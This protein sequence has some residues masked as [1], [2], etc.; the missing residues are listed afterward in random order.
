MD[1][2]VEEEVEETIIETTTVPAVPIQEPVAAPVVPIQEPIS[3]PSSPKPVPAPI[4]EPIPVPVNDE[5]D[6]SVLDDSSK[7][8]RFN[9]TDAVLTSTNQNQEI[10]VPKDIHSIEEATN[11]R[12]ARQRLEEE[13][14]SIGGEVDTDKFTIL[15][16]DVDPSAF[17]I[18]PIGQTDDLDLDI[19]ILQ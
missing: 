3:V 12:Q 14:N 9:D 17:E 16:T 11:V 2:T 18:Q 4:Q 5:I 7:N 6:T 13:Q 15:D 8:L 19:E 10:N 1:N